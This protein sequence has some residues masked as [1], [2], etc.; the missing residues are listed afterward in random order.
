MVLVS[1]KLSLLPK[2]RRIARGTR[3]IVMQNIVG[4]LIIKAAIMALDIAIA[5]FPLI[6]SVVADVGVMLVAVLNALRTNLLK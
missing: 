2:G 1:D 5:G 4:S 6:I 3:S